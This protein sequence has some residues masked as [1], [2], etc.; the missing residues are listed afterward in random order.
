MNPPC[1]KHLAGRRSAAAPS[2]ACTGSEATAVGGGAATMMIIQP[3]ADNNS[4]KRQR[5]RTSDIRF[6]RSDAGRSWTPAAF[7]L[8][9]LLLLS[10]LSL[11]ADTE[12]YRDDDALETASI[13]HPVPGVRRDP[14]LPPMKVAIV[15]AGG[16]SG[17]SAFGETL[18]DIN[19]QS[20]R[21]GDASAGCWWDTQAEDTP[22]DE[23]MKRRMNI[24]RI[25]KGYRSMPHEWFKL[26]KASMH[27][28]KRGVPQELIEETHGTE[29]LGWI[30]EIMLNGLNDS[31]CDIAWGKINYKIMK[32]EE[33]SVMPVLRRW[34]TTLITFGR[35]N[36]LDRVLCETTDCFSDYPGIYNVHTSN[37]TLY[38]PISAPGENVCFFEN[39]RQGGREKR[40]TSPYLD[41]TGRPDEIVKALK[42]AIR[43][44]NRERE[45]FLSLGFGKI[46]PYTYDDMFALTRTD[47]EGAF[48]QGYRL[49]HGI[50]QDLGL[51][52]SA[53]RGILSSIR[54]SRPRSPTRVYNPNESREF[55]FERMPGF[56]KSFWRDAAASSEGED[57]RSRVVMSSGA[58]RDVFSPSQL[59]RGPAFSVLVLVFLAAIITLVTVSRRIGR[60]GGGVPTRRRG[61]ALGL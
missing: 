41:V 18:R 3:D 61:D 9:L 5:Q 34:N 49:W 40:L 55:L 52:D 2:G 10:L 46:P 24:P 43:R 39:R 38:N 28:L 16:C 1:K 32:K 54:G 13:R 60:G 48:E 4:R 59:A 6:Y 21:P 33:A 47:D 44:E 51:R 23:A 31:G 7:L 22:I 17:S 20:R 37:G 27:L 29:G 30:V 58:P 57:G 14:S 42:G 12:G 36:V 50:F 15:G 26:H 53:L 11:C 45:Y 19:R 35:G 25:S 8:L 56:A